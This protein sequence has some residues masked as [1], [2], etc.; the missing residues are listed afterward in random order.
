MQNNKKFLRDIS[1]WF[2]WFPFRL[3]VRHLPIKWLNLMGQ[4]GGM[5][6][7][8]FSRKKREIMAE[9]LSFLFSHSSSLNQKEIKNMVSRGLQIFSKRQME[10]LYWGKMSPQLIEQMITVEGIKHLEKALQNKCGAILLTAH[11][12]SHMLPLFA[13]AFEGYKVNQIAGPPLIE[14]Q[15]SIHSRIFKTRSKESGRLPVNFITLDKP[16]RHLFRLLRDN[17]I[18]FIAFDGR[19]T[20]KMIPVNFFNHIAF[21]AGGPFK[22]SLMTKAPILPVFIVRNKDDK[23]RLIIEPPFEFELAGDEE[24]KIA[25][26]TAKFAKK[27]EEYILKYPCHYAMTLMRMKEL[28][29][30]GA[31][32]SNLFQV[33]KREVLGKSM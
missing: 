27:F 33:H 18:L 31:L 24:N 4:L 20:N 15:T 22:L 21:F 29:Q 19:E 28:L 23:H 8:V 30:Q 16:K 17:E 9:E 25:V 3:F 12:G 10:N 13:L 5:A 14:K 6:L 32:E 2:I 7:Y 11:F 1:L 26:N